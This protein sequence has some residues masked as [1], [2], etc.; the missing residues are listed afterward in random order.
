MF[1]CLFACASVL[2]RWIP[3]VNLCSQQPIA[4]RANLGEAGLVEG[5]ETI[6]PSPSPLPGRLT[7]TAARYNPAG[8][9]HPS[10]HSNS[11]CGNSPIPPVLQVI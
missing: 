9:D 4:P 8:S 6:S 1:A 7:P 11:S 10:D 3:T 5:G 2:V